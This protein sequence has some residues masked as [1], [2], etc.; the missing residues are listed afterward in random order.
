MDKLTLIFLTL[1]LPAAGASAETLLLRGATVHTVTHGTLAPGDVLVRDGKIAAV[2]SRIEEPADRAIDLAGLHLFPGLVSASTDL[3]LVEIS[4]V[5]ASLD[6]QE[7]GEFTPEIESW[8]AVNPDSELIPVT[9]ANGITHFVPVP[10]GSL[11]SGASS[12]MAAR[13]WTIEDMTVRRRTAMHLFWPDHSLRVPGPQVSEKVKPLD[14]QARERSERV[15]VIDRFFAD[16]EA[17]EKRRSDSPAVPAW[18]AMLP[19][20]RGEL[21]LVVHAQGLRE[22]RAALKWSATHPRLRLILDGGRDAWMVA[23]ELAQRKIPV[24]YSE[25]FTLPAQSSDAYDV[26]VGAPAVLEIAGVTVAI[27]DGSDGSASSQRNL[28]YTAAQAVAFG[29]SREAALASITLVPAQLHGLGDQLG[30]IDVG[31][32]ASLFAATGD[33]LDIRSEVRHLWIAGTD[34]SLASRHTRLAD[35]YRSRPAK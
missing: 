29:F 3:G 24:I 33:I 17:W 4:A 19:V 31:K 23:D 1:L 35:R 16:A 5:R 11:I 21:P 10:S 7:T 20:V 34:Q 12:M 6:V 9:R 13:G 26:Q 18:E 28:P 32:E 27:S 25:V 2:A 30:S 14:E 15:R 22:I 8:T